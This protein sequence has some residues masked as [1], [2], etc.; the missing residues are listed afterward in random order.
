MAS[1]GENHLNIISTSTVTDGNIE[2]VVRNRPVIDD[3]QLVI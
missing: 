2:P 1:F 3:T